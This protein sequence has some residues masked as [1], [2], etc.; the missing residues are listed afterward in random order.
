MTA[1]MK[2]DTQL[3]ASDPVE[4]PATAR[5]LERRGYD[6]IW[7]SETAHDPFLPLAV[8][9]YHTERIALGTA[10]TVAF[11]RNPMTVA[12]VANDLQRYCHGRFRLGLGSQVR[13]HIERRFSMPWSEPAQRMREFIAALSAVWRSWESGEPLR[14]TGKFYRHTLMTPFFTPQPHPFGRPPVLLAA[15]GPAMTRV[16][17]EV[18]DGILLHSFSSAEYVRAKVLPAIDAELAARGRGR[19]S[20][21][22]AAR[23]FVASGRTAAEVAAAVAGVRRQISF[24]GSTPAYRPILTFHGHG[25]LADE[26]HRLSRTDDDRRWQAMADLVPDDLLETL[27]L[28][29]SGSEVA[30]AL[31]TRYGDFADRLRL[32]TPYAHGATVE[33]EIAGRWR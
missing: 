13:G 21:E 32:Y 9:S 24:Y 8:A 22:I 7:T 27:A 17:G 26:L 6:G 30:D 3:V 12:Y 14:F 18:A 28:T 19:E 2:L 11:S 1:A 5:D 15:V 23:A 4:L 25:D 31:V 10:V 16:A 33:R 29:G 20:F